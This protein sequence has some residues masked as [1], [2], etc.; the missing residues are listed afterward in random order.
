M[1][2]FKMEKNQKINCSVS[3]CKYNNSKDRM[4]ILEAIQVAP[5]SG[6][7]SKNSDE[8]MCTSYKYNK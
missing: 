3:S 4:C 7:Q 1:E 8:S 5:T 6:N 2:V